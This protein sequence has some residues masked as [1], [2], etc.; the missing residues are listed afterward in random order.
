VVLLNRAIAL[1]YVVDAATALREVDALTDSLDRYH[2]FHEHA[3]S[4]FAPSG[5]AP[6]RAPRTNARSSSRRIPRSGR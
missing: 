1:R 3:P 4:C 6:R 2:V 5:A